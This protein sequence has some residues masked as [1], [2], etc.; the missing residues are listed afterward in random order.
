ML[1][2]FS[3]KVI[4]WL[5]IGRK[6]GYRTANINLKQWLIPSWTYMINGVIWKKI[7]F[8]VWS[9]KEELSLF[10]A[11]FLDFDKNIYWKN[12]EIIVLEPIRE[13]REFS[14]L[15]E[16]QKQIQKDIKK[17]R[18]IKNIGMAFWTFDILH[19]WHKHYLHEARKYC[20]FLVTV[21]ARDANVQKIKWSFPQMNEKERKNKV[22]KLHISDTVVLWDTLDPL[23]WIK[24]ISPSVLCLWYDQTWFLSLL[25]ASAMDSKPQIIRISPYKENLY[26]SSLLKKRNIKEKE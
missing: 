21:I 11:H 1:G 8:W 4:H 15:W 5:K 17:A 26:K 10:E 18:Q 24:K 13:N 23:K 2:H 14:Q 6:I 12:I 20:T 3:W 25:E 22:E 19:K 7:Y 16:I 9:Y